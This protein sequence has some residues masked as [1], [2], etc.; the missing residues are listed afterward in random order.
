MLAPNAVV[1]SNGPGASV[2]MVGA[3]D[4]FGDPTVTTHI[5][6]PLDELDN[7]RCVK[8]N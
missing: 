6:A 8:I 1:G 3:A 4:P 5:N 7:Y 2:T